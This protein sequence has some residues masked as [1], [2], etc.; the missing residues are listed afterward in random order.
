MMYR[1]IF[2]DKK[3]EFLDPTKVFYDY[4]NKTDYFDNIVG[5]KILVWYLS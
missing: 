3:P 1:G 2:H 5:G 4:C